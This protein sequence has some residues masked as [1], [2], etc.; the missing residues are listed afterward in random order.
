MDFDV[1]AWWSIKQ[2]EFPDVA[3]LARKYLNIQASSAPS[4]RVFSAA[5]DL[6][7][8]KRWRLSDDRLKNAVLCRLNPS[9]CSYAAQDID[10]AISAAHI[11]SDVEDIIEYSEVANAN[12]MSDE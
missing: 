2:K 12:E 4:E 10:D 7:G 6:G 9:F 11:D 1:L 5:G 3:K 8:R